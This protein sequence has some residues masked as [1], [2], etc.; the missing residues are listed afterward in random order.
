[1]ITIPNSKVNVKINCSKCPNVI[2]YSR[3]DE[4]RELLIRYVEF[5]KIGGFATTLDIDEKIPESQY[6]Q[7]AVPTSKLKRIKKLLENKGCEI[8]IE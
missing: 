2:E 8:I 1:M 3:Y 6:I 7:V 4:K 5:E